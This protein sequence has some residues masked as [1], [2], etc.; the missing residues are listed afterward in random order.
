MLLVVSELA[1]LFKKVVQNDLIF[2]VLLG[3]FGAVSSFTEERINMVETLLCD[4]F[5]HGRVMG[6]TKVVT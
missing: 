1:I 4:K 2:C 3:D 5:I 6:E